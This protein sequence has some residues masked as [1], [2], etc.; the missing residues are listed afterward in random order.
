MVFLPIAINI[1]G[2]KILIIGGGNVG[3]HKATLLMRYAD[4]ATVISPT[5]LDGFKLLPF[6]LI[7]KRYEP[8]DLLGAFLVYVCTEDEELNRRI[9]RDAEALGILTSVCDNPALCDF[10]SPA[11]HQDG[12]VSVAVTSNGEDVRRSIAVRDKIKHLLEW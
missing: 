4:T 5:F 1:T 3:L 2:K 6:T 8:S 12:N 10:I 9:K 11:I 7:E